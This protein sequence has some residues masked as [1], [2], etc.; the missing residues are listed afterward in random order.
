MADD[1]II[2]LDN[3]ATTQ[4]DPAVVEEM[5][6]FLTKYY[7][8]PSSGYGFAAKARKAVDL[9]RERLAALL[10]CESPEIVFTS[11]GTESNN[12]AIAS[13]LQF[14]PRG[15]HVVTS[16]VEHSA[17]LRPCQDLTKRGC[18]VAFLAVDRDGNVDLDEL[19]A[20]IL[21]ETALV[22][23]MWANNETGVLFPVAKIAEVCR[24]KGVLFH[25]DA[26]QAAGKIPMRVRDTAINFLSLSA[27]KFHGPK[28]IGALYVSRR[29]RFR[30]L[31]AGGGQ[32]N[33]RRGGSENVASIVGLG[34][35]AEAASEYLS[36]GKAHV[37]SMRD[38]FEK[39]V[40]EAV[41]GA[42]VNGAGV[43]RIPNTSSF[44]FEGIESPAALLLLDRYRIC[45]SA[46]SACR[47][48]SQEAS[49]VLRAMDPS[50]DGARRSLRFSFGRFNT[51][52]QVDRAIEVVPKVIEKLR[53]IA[54]PA[55][56]SAVSPLATAP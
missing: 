6:P 46:G 42:A 8:N 56:G 40:L 27:H 37:R 55:R 7:G 5:M 41:S 24:E 26:V 25:T 50:G 53:Q 13:S 47:T 34:K 10:G 39:A 22:S 35:A 11:G 9:A 18:E 3:N 29:T 15:K 36:E 1:E 16:A 19:E 17:V 49:H 28:G 31:I 54:A 21:P 23:M 38:R 45:C 14:E 51:D 4:L 52:A 43:A 2:Y 44:S 20:A 12:T 32:E 48:G 33:E 30:P